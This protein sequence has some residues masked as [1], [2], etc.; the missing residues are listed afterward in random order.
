MNRQHTISGGIVKSWFDE[1]NRQ[2][3]A[4]TSLEE[5]TGLDYCQ[6][7]DID[8]RIPL[9]QHHKLMEIGI[10]LTRNPAL[11]LQM[12]E[13]FSPERLGVVGHVFMNC[14][15]LREAGYQAIRYSKLIC[16]VSHLALDEDEKHAKLVHL[17]EIPEYDSISSSEASLSSAISMIRVFSGN[18][19]NP[20]ETHFQHA[21]PDHIEEYKRIFQAPIVFN[22]PENALIFDKKILES[23]LSDFNPY[24][25]E[26]LIKHADE[27]LHQLSS[28][29]KL[30]DQV[31][32]YIFDHLSKG[33]VDIEMVALHLNMSRW[34]LTRKL[35][36]EGTSFQELFK[37]MRKKMA[38]NYLQIKN[39]SI[40]E[41][42]F[43]VGFSEPS[44]F[45]RAFKNWAGQSPGEFRKARTLLSA[46]S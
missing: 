21:K 3:I 33:E 44:T 34:T 46:A 18:A 32:T 10:E 4:V 41:V 42:A 43:M 38:M 13:S 23:R 11:A 16:E 31:C 6:L 1:L 5:K 14:P 28:G 35:K 9:Q 30:Q 17:I 8:A 39:F 27:L 37:Q 7:E 24:L 26:I 19:V 20:I 2:G 45:N 29:K 12:G 22:Q 25:H 36:E 40:S 15:T